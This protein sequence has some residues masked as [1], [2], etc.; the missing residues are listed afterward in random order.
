MN[1]TSPGLI[2][3]EGRD[4]T[5]R[6][7]GGGRTSHS[8]QLGARAINGSRAPVPAGRARGAG[9]GRPPHAPG[10]GG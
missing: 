9:S 3:G 10:T 6:G 5:S 8:A 2:S 4:R 1:E 7:V